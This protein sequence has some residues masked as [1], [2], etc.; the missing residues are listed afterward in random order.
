MKRCFFSMNCILLLHICNLKH[1]FLLDLY[2]K[3]SIVLKQLCSPF[4][5][6]K[7]YWDFNFVVL[8]DGFLL[9]LHY[10]YNQITIP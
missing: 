6:R 7:V 2:S 9:N 1:T 8:R 10:F 5:L 4:Y 3:K